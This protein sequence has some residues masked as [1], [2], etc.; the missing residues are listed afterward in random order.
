VGSEEGE[1]VGKGKDRTGRWENGK[2]RGNGRRKTK[3]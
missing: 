2:L 3:N 1:K